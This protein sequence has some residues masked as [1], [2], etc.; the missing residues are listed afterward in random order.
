MQSLQAKLAPAKTTEMT[1]SVNSYPF[2]EA[3]L[4]AV[5]GR[6][7]VLRVLG[8]GGMGSV[9]LAHDR[10][11]DRSVAIKFP[12]RAANPE[13]L[14]RMLREARAA[15]KVSHPNVCAV[16]DVGCEL[17]QPFFTM[18]FVP[19]KSLDKLIR[20]GKLMSTEA[21]VNIVMKIAAGLIKAHG[22]QLT[23]RD[24]KPANI[25]I[26]ANGEPVVTDF[27]L[28]THHGM[29]GCGVT[30][31]K[32]VG[33]PSYM[34]PEQ[35]RCDTDQIGPATDVYGLGVILYELLTGQRPFSGEVPA[36]YTK[37]LKQ[38][39]VMPTRIVP[40][41]NRGLE[42][43]CLRAIAKSPQD[44]FHS[45]AEFRIALEQWRRNPNPFQLPEGE[46]IQLQSPHGRSLAESMYELESRKV[47]TRVEPELR[48]WLGKPWQKYRRWRWKL[49]RQ[50]LGFISGIVAA[51]VV[52]WLLF[53]FALFLMS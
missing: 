49:S 32:V 19:G 17:G 44:R 1:Q 53:I 14:E 39:P 51:S 47:H 11:L 52:C 23:H 10:V 8:V 4:P 15:A 6:Y 12:N 18:E 21:A 9:Y 36:V 2:T 26:R 3:Q 38:Q 20:P 28:A 27:G 24:L 22:Q 42:A 13:V 16:F 35:V 7:E 40:S 30:E 31:E 33:S 41:L 48:K 25:L 5:F 50:R 29:T 43:I 45:I 37:I 34:S 46:P